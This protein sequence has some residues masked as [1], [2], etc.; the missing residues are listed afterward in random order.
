MDY[1]NNV[2]KNGDKEVKMSKKAIVVRVL[3]LIFLVLCLV[4]VAFAIGYMKGMD[5]GVKLQRVAS[6]QTVKVDE[7]KKE[8]TKTENADIEDEDIEKQDTEE[9]DTDEHVDI[10]NIYR[11][12]YYD[13]FS[14][15]DLL[16]DDT[17]G[18]YF[19]AIGDSVPEVI[20][21]QP[22]ENHGYNEKDIYLY[23]INSH[24]EVVSTYLGKAVYPWVNVRYIKGKT[25]THWQFEQDLESNLS[26]RLIEVICVNQTTDGLE[27]A[28]SFLG[29]IQQTGLNTLTFTINK[30]KDCLAYEEDGRY[31]KDSYEWDEVL[32][33]Y[34]DRD[35]GM[36]IDFSDAEKGK[37]EILYA[38]QHE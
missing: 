13:Y 23:V 35:N 8:E 18:M 33:K 1:E 25:E 34:F 22:F 9:Q 21:I 30:D 32:F 24:G 10:K 15:S 3:L 31:I 5:E 20:L 14:S 36:L 16:Q 11:Q 29:E 37:E 7:T 17:M 19:E 12:I 4:A 38:V 2:V 6:D 28:K 26:T 27:V